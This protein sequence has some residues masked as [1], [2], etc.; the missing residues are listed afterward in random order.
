MRRF[1][2]PPTLKN[3]ND[4]QRKCDSVSI[5]HYLKL[6][7]VVLRL[8]FADVDTAPPRS[9]G[10]CRWAVGSTVCDAIGSNLRTPSAVSSSSAKYAMLVVDSS[11]EGAGAVSGGGEGIGV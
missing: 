10:R 7:G 5:G 11:G 8:G 9:V 3:Q 1:T 2:R 6:R 4:D